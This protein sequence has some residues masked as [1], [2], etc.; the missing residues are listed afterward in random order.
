MTRSSKPAHTDD[1]GQFPGAWLSELTGPNRSRRT[2]LAI[3]CTGNIVGAIGAALFL[4]ASWN[5]Y[6][7]TH[8]WVGA[9][10]LINELWIVIAYLVRRPALRLEPVIGFWL[11]AALSPERSFDRREPISTSQ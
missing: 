10:F 6:H 5:H 4:R 8:S 11:S 1:R 7:S 3:R 9:G 2:R